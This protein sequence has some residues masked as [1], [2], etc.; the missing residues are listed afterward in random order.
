MTNIR[1]ESRSRVL[2]LFRSLVFG[3]AWK[4]DPDKGEYLCG[5]RGGVLPP[6]IG[7]SVSRAPLCGVLMKM[8]MMMII[9]AVFP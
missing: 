3:F 6:R 7:K 9:V 2:V 4:V 8:K 1:Y 5:G